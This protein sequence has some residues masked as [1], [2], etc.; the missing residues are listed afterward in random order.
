[1]PSER[2]SFIRGGLTVTN[3]KN[4]VKQDRA[5]ANKIT[6][7]ALISSSIISG[8]RQ[9]R[10]GL[11]SLHKDLQDNV[12]LFFFLNCNTEPSSK[13]SATQ[14][15]EMRS[16]WNQDACFMPGSRNSHFSTKRSGKLHLPTKEMDLCGGS[17]WHV[18][19]C[20]CARVPLYQCVRTCACVHRCF[21][22]FR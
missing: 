22:Q 13:E 17:R 5:R 11:H 9:S 16:P 14:V 7:A 2:N 4:L 6:V 20:T 8:L 15:P 3:L 12:R 21:A 10:P 18:R 19:V 1:M